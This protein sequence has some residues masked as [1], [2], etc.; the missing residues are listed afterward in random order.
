[1]TTASPS[2]IIFSSRSLAVSQ[3]STYP[4]SSTLDDVDLSRDRLVMLEAIRTRRS[5]A[6]ISQ[7][8]QL[9][10]RLGHGA[11]ARLLRNGSRFWH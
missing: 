5:A 8:Q 6:E 7:T 3:S 11:E 9:L 10:K 4:T 2:L 1:M